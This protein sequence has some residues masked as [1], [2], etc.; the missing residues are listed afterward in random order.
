MKTNTKWRIIV[1]P[2][3]LMRQGFVNVLIEAGHT[4]CVGFE[5]VEEME[6]SL[7]PEARD[8]MIL[9]NLGSEK[10]KVASGIEDLKVRHP[11]SPI[12]LLSNR[13]CHRHLQT[14]FKAGASGY[15]LT[16]TSCEALIKSLQVISLGQ[17]VIPEEALGLVLKE[18]CDAVEG[19]LTTEAELSSVATGLL[20]ERELVVLRCLCSAMSNKLIARECNI[21]EATVKVHVKAILRKINGKNRTEAALW[22]LHQGLEPIKPATLRARSRLNCAAGIAKKLSYRTRIETE[23]GSELTA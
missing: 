1:E 11:E 9:A 8:G 7:D 10:D 21:C 17:P 14:A 20:S 19:A 15:I 3:E 6:S 22:A 13:Y 4:N 18:E 23:G 2:N 12:V 5:S 16:S